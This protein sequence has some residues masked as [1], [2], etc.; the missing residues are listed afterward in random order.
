MTQYQR[1]E[2]QG[3]NLG[4]EGQDCVSLLYVFIG[5]NQVHSPKEESRTPWGFPFLVYVA[6]QAAMILPSPVPASDTH[7]RLPSGHVHAT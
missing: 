1:P 6:A 2:Q 7:R 5:L 3:V 4:C